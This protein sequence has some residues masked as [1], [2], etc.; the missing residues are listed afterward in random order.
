MNTTITLTIL[1]VYLAMRIGHDTGDHPMQS[2]RQARDKGTSWR[3]LLGHVGTYTVCTATVVL[4][5]GLLP[6]VT[7][8]PAGFLLGQAF[9]AATHLVIDRRPWFAA[10]MERIGKGEFYRLAPPLGGAYL[11]DQ[12]AHRVCIAVAAVITG[13]A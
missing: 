8:T 9:S 4:L 3:S 7:F 10:A 13:V 6:G 1:A 12:W 2:S 5:A 11:L